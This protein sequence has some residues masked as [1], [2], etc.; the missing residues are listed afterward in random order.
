LTLLSLLSAL[1]VASTAFAGVSIYAQ[2]ADDNMTST[3]DSGLAGNATSLDS[4]ADDSSDD[5]SV[6]ASE[7]STA[8]SIA[9]LFSGLVICDLGTLT[10]GDA[11]EVAADA[12]GTQPTITITVMDRTEIA[13]AAENETSTAASSTDCMQLGETSTS[14][15]TESTDLASDDNATSTTASS[16]ATSVGDASA[17]DEELTTFEEEALLD[18]ES[19]NATSAANAT[20]SNSTDMSSNATSTASTDTGA[21]EGQ[22]VAID[23]EDFAPGQ[24]VLVFTD[25]ALIAVDDVADDGSIDAKV[26]MEDVDSEL[27]FVESGTLRTATASF[28]EG[29]TVIAGSEDQDILI[30]MAGDSEDTETASSF[31]SSN[32][33]STPSGNATSTNSTSTNS[34]NATGQ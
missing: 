29:D 22:V 31:S 13:A 32:S 10:V 11:T 2:Q 30:V 15:A 12:N 18:S 4:S 28:A 33:T 7:T 6:D 25:N 3:E 27:R 5:S 23:G 9:D 24:V 20:D 19:G 16:N 1:V 26:P 14:N 34:T 21:D 8:A 17:S